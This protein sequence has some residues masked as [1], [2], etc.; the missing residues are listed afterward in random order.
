MELQQQKKRC[1]VSLQVGMFAAVA[2]IAAAAAAAA[3]VAALVAPLLRLETVITA[4][5]F[6]TMLRCY[7]HIS[8]NHT[9]K[10]RQ[11]M[12]CKECAKLADIHCWAAITRHRTLNN[13]P[14]HLQ[15]CLCLPQ[16]NCPAALQSVLGTVP[17]KGFEW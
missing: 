17:S 13:A 8:F 10:L 14:A 15:C 7:Q 16:H 9:S 12:N 6:V 5:T 11:P 2:A 1:I 3:A 4:Y